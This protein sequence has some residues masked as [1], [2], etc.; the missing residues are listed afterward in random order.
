MYSKFNDM[1]NMTINMNSNL[2]ENA[3]IKLTK[4]K[5]MG[6]NSNLSVFQVARLMDRVK[7]YTTSEG[8]ANPMR[9]FAN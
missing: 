3:K 8:H 6:Q 4:H 9:F 1:Q 2:I 5:E 7:N